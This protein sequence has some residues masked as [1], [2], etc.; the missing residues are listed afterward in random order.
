[1]TQHSKPSNPH[2]ATLKPSDPYDASAI[3]HTLAITTSSFVHMSTNS[4]CLGRLSMN[5]P[6][7]TN[8]RALSLDRFNVHQSPLQGGSSAGLNLGTLR[9]Q[10]HDHDHE[11]FMAT[12]WCSKDRWHLQSKKKRMVR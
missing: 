11:A 1:M 6:H 4:L 12:A 10:V 2:D 3:A 5:L 7:P 8:G 9:P